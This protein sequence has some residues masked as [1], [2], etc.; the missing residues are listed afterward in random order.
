MK[1]LIYAQSGGPTAVINASASGVIS[2]AQK[3]GFDKILCANF[4]V[5]GIIA[6]NFYDVTNLDKTSLELLSRT[7]SSAFGS[8]RHKLTNADQ[9]DSEYRKIASVISKYNVTCLILNGGNDSMHTAKQLANYFVKTNLH[10][11]VVGVP[12]TV[13][14][15]LIGTD[16]CPGYGSACKYIADTI[17]NIAL[18]T[19]SY[20]KGRVTICEVMGRDTGW[21][22]ASASLANVNGNG[23]DL[24]YL[25][26]AHFDKQ[27]FIEQVQNVYQSK[28]RCLV[29]MAEG[30]GCGK[31]ASLDGF[32]HAQLGG[33]A[34]ELADF[35]KNTLGYS[36]RAI[37]LSLPQ[38]ASGQDLSQTDVNCAFACGQQAVTLANNGTTGVMV[39]VIRTKDG[40]DYGQIALDEVATKVK[41]LPQEYFTDC[42]VTQKFVDYALPLIQGEVA[43]TY[44]NGIAQYFDLNK[45]TKYKP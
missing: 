2:Q 12:K 18:D 9:N 17:Q 6:E 3:Y 23:P 31:V 22:T 25:P 37:E 39:T 33:V 28:K 14:N 32:A 19:S 16:F 45:L 5:D 26:E 42:N 1:T 30:I 4:G 7:P 20:A 34:Y 38:R 41:Y 43:Q 10:C 24:I 40:F 11:A 44:V 13:D 29:A 8:C 21:L 36:T 35:V 27:T 15:D